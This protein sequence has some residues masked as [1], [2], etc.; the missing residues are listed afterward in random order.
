VSPD[1]R[2]IVCVCAL[3]TLVLGAAL[4]L[5]QTDIKK[6]LAYSTL[7]NLAL[8]FLA[9]A[10][11]STGAGM[12]HL[13][14][15][16]S[17]KALLF[18]AAGSVIFSAHHEQDVR[19]LRGVLKKLPVTNIA[20]LV[21]CIGGAGLIP[22]LAAGF[23]S[24]E[25]V[26]GALEAAEFDGFGLH[27]SGH[28]VHAIVVGVET[29]SVL[30]LFRLYGY[31]RSDATGPAFSNP[32]H[33]AK[34]VSGQASKAVSGRNAHG[35]DAHDDHAHG[36]HGAA[37]KE[38]SPAITV[39]LGILILGAFAFGILSAS[40]SFGGKGIIWSAI[41]G[42][43]A[44][45]E[46]AHLTHAGTLIPLVINLLL[47]VLCFAVFSNT[48]RREALLGRLKVL[49]FGA[50]GPL[51][52]KFY[53]DDVYTALIEVPLKGAAYLSRLILENVFTGLITMTGW[54][55]QGFS[56]GLRRLQS[57]KTHQYAIVVLVAVFLLAFY[58]GGH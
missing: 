5:V 52:R 57:G 21:G 13:F 1:A 31:L 3:V 6:I 40:P 18:L 26:L 16:A 2:L 11:G 46:G 50:F 29:L 54:L 30:Y 42:G 49:R 48:K 34:P 10:A 7:S 38:T 41:T 47:A 39:V 14:G 25:A 17:F 8:M 43:R 15:H 4:A 58:L 22:F 44:E 24:K 51:T 27:L 28:I 9:L 20:F 12:L 33:P 19:N 56:L 53:F 45:P 36:A 55:G 32:A 37:V 23:F 35:H